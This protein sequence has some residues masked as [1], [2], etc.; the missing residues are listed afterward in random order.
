[1]N[2]LLVSGLELMLVGMG[3]VF[4]FLVLLVL[5]TRLMSVLINKYAFEAGPHVLAARTDVIDDELRQVIL[6][7]VHL[8][9][10]RRGIS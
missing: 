4:V 9:R 2:P 10:R 8:H 1:M 7:A 3:T 6:E 5:A